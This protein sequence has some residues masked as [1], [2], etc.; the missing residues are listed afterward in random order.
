[1]NRTARETFGLELDHGSQTDETFKRKKQTQLV[2][3]RLI[4]TSNGYTP[5]SNKASDAVKQIKADLHGLDGNDH[6][7]D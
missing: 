7:L 5:M 4:E 3:E 6:P 2:N 1:M